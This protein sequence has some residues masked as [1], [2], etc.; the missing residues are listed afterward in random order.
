MI[1]I[2]RKDVKFTI[3]IKSITPT[4]QF[5][6]YGSVFGIL[7][8]YKD[9]VDAGAFIRTLQY[10]QGFTKVMWQHDYTNPIAWATANEDR[11]GLALEGQLLIEGGV[12]R[13]GEVLTAKDEIPQARYAYTLMKAGVI[14]GLSIGYVPV[15]E[16]R[17]DNGIRH[18]S[19][20]KLYEVSLVTFPAN[21]EAL[22]FGV[23]NYM[24]NNNESN[25]TA[26]R[27]KMLESSRE[28]RE[29]IKTHN[30]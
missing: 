8:S 4:G 7:D 25:I 29:L 19:E 2:E 5:S 22:I 24:L 13:N 30:C 10:K 14:D 26:L 21:E 1:N 23:K 9:V 6:G 15:Q 20:V 12:N 17:D 28:L 3:N 18:L 11:Y 27:L 16:Y